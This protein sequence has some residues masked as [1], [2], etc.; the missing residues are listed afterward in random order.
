[1]VNELLNVVM[2]NCCV[3]IFVILLIHEIFTFANFFKCDETVQ[4]CNWII[5]QSARKKRKLVV[6][7]IRIENGR[8]P[9][10]PGRMKKYEIFS[11]SRKSSVLDRVSVP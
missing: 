11:E 6:I 7:G 1:M 8:A 5:G 9:K 3:S 2:Y 10:A 4:K